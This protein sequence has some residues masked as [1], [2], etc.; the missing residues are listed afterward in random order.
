MWG[1][2]AFLMGLK[3]VNA[4]PSSRKA[5]FVDKNRRYV[6]SVG[7]LTSFWKIWPGKMPTEA[8]ANGF[9][10]C[11]SDPRTHISPIIVH[12]ALFFEKKRGGKSVG[13]GLVG[14]GDASSTRGIAPGSRLDS[15]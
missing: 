1:Y 10:R 15:P 12:R 3:H 7:R 4:T 13:K 11:P 2:F 6:R 9:L 5:P 8:R 14:G